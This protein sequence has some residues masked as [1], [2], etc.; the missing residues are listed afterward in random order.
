MFYD[1][2][3]L[4]I[5]LANY[6]RDDKQ[7]AGMLKVQ[8]FIKER[9]IP[10]IIQEKLE[11]GAVKDAEKRESN[12]NGALTNIGELM[13]FADKYFMYYPKLLSMMREVNEYMYDAPIMPV[14][15]K[16]RK[17]DITDEIRNLIAEFAT[18]KTHERNLYSS[19]LEYLNH[20]INTNLNPQ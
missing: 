6:C 11:Q 2:V 8:S 20:L 9:A 10:F 17:K 16:A 7:R 4:D 5:S 14:T 18:S 13:D 1:N 19:A 12:L 15:T 3:E